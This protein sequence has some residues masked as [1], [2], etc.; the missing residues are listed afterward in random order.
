MTNHLL[1]GLKNKELEDF[2]VKN[3]LKSDA[4][5]ETIL[6][7]FECL[8]KYIWDK[9]FKNGL[10]KICGRQPLKN[11]KEY[12]LLGPFLNTLSH[13]I[14][15]LQCLVS[16]EGHFIKLWAILRVTCP[17]SRNKIMYLPRKFCSFRGP[18]CK[19][20]P[21]FVLV[22]SRKMREMGKSNRFFWPTRWCIPGLCNNFPTLQ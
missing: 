6:S 15:L 1:K 14:Y 5:C 7:K 22:P 9:V 4:K 11:L 8:H 13:M 3:K 18:V 10:S 2:C 21:Q 17:T 12:D 16:C 20:V 19:Y